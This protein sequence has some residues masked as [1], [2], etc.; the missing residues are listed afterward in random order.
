MKAEIVSIGTELLLGEITDTN[1]SFIAGQLPGL[2]IDLYWISMVGDNVAR[3]AE[4][5][6]RAWQRSDII[7]TTGGLGP[8]DGDVTRQSIAAMLCEEIKV[9]SLLEVEI[10][11]YF[12]RRGI[13]M[14]LNNLRQATLIPSA[15]AVHNVR[16]TA[17]GWWV[18]KDGHLLV[19]MPGPPGEMQNMWHTEIL[20]RLRQLCPENIIVSRI[21]K[22]FGVSESKLGET[23]TE[24]F[25]ASNPTM[26]IYA[27]P[28]GVHLRLAAKAPTRQQAE[29]IIAREETR[30]RAALGDC[31]WGT[32]NDTLEAVAGRKLTEKGLT[33]AVMESVTG[34]LLAS[35]LADVPGA[36]KYFKGGPVALSDEAK[37]A[38]GVSSRIISD[39]GSASTGTALAMAETVRK[40]LEA[41]IGIGVTGTLPGEAGRTFGVVYIAVTDG[42]NPVSA[43]WSF[44]GDK[45]RMKRLAISRALFELIKML[46]ACD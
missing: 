18:E 45:A 44:P 15:K 6:G 16:G 11:E 42:R 25:R 37:L 33:L 7:L 19:A 5:L 39:C 9:D 36:S 1:S 13:P 21:L 3:I 23:V 29:E 27:K 14:S 34:G 2:G 22:T 4:V 43:E 40:N 46:G 30:V 28:D 35:A 12:A 24:W 38:Y 8:T 20:P 26:G 31:I 10:R 32:D 41:D 17:P